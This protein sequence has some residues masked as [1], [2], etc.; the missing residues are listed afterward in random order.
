MKKILMIVTIIFIVI[1][2]AVALSTK[3]S[4]KTLIFPT[5]IPLPSGYDQNYSNMNYLK[6]G[7]STIEDTIKING[8]PK[9]RS[10]FGENTELIYE[11]PNSS[12]TNTAVFKNNVLQ[13][14]V[15]HVFSSY[16]GFL[17]DY[18][19]TYGTPLLLY[20][21]NEEG[22]D[23]YVFLEHGVGIESSN[24]EITKILYFVPQDKNSFL[25]TVGSEVGISEEP[26][27]P[28]EEVFEL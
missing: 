18:L 25:E 13:Y 21:K 9:A 17:S 24:D 7:E 4:E 23:W 11:T 6:P 22:F 14:A 16:R 12:Y 8:I 5:P 19:K 15:E 20:S 27:D 2:I 3:K 1:I 10:S 26:L 28:I